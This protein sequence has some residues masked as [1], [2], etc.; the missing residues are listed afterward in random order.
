MGIMSEHLFYNA[1][2][3]ALESDYRAMARL[4]ERHETWESAYAEVRTRTA[5]PDPESAWGAMTANDIR[6]TLLGDAAYPAPLAEIPNPPFGIYSK[7]ILAKAGIPLG[8]VGT[9][10]ATP[11][12]KDAAKEFARTLA[13]NDFAIVSG[14]AFGIDC[15]AHDGCLDGGGATIAVLANGLDSVYP[16]TNAPLAE[17]ILKNGGALISEY[18]PGSPPLPY[19]FL[20]RNRIVSGLSKGILVVECP[21]KSGALATARFAFE[22]NRDVFVVPGPITH[23]NFFGS[24]AL[25]RQ[26]AELVTKPE[27]ILE[28]YGIVRE[29]VAAKEEIDASP[30][31]KLILQA[32]RENNEP[33]DVDKIISLT[34]LEPRIANQ[35]I[36]FLLLRGLVKENENGYTI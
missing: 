12:G 36:T 24:H 33:L 29:D 34:R 5:A 28:S 31:E 9:R 6:L 30:E 27:D 17:R 2:A 26:G 25:I 21:A 19:R 16:A 3:V 14:L 1:V 15:A 18:P 13:E 32:L 35:T 11:R 4:R 7:G 22:Q 8:I 20:E 10:R 23:P